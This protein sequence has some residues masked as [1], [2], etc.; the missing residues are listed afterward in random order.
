MNGDAAGWIEALSGEPDPHAITALRTLLLRGLTR[1]LSRRS[2]IRNDDFED[3]A[4][5]AILKIIDRLDNFRGDSKFETWAM[6]V[7]IR[8][9]LSTLRQRRWRDVPFESM[10]EPSLC[11]DSTVAEDAVFRQQM[12]RI[13]MQSIDDLSSRQRDIVVAELRGMP[14]ETIAAKLGTTR[15]A[16]YKAYHDARKNLRRALENAGFSLE[17]VR[18]HLE[19]A[20]YE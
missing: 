11:S 16:V 13:L 8:T 2:E 7:A 19:G 6:S 15:G 1:A 10:T 9:A 17:E 14:A 3:F 18:Q 5:E 20:S 4:Q 12:I